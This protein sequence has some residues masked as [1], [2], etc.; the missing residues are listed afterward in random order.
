ME[1]I[2][3]K[4]IFGAGSLLVTLVPAGNNRRS[5]HEHV[6]RAI[7]ALM[8]SNNPSHFTLPGIDQLAPDLKRIST[9][10]FQYY[11]WE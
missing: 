3:W 5:S 4:L 10:A 11:L 8:A 1:I 6:G 7:K 9:S 2:P